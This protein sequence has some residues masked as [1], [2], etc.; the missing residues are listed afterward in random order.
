MILGNRSS[1]RVACHLLDEFV[2]RFG[3]VASFWMKVN[4]SIS[5][6]GST[7]S[8]SAQYLKKK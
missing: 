3:G 2:G 4:L 7:V 5:H 6:N 1:E 8:G